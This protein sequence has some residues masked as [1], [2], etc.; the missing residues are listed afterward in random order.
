MIYQGSNLETVLKE[1]SEKEYTPV[2]ELTYVVLKNEENNVEIEVYTIVDVIEYAQNY[3]IDGIKALGFDSR[4]NP[5]LKDDIINL[6]IESDRNPI[7]IGKNGRSLQAL[8]E[9]V[10]LAVNHR[11]NRR[12]RILLNVSDY[13]EEKYSKISSFAKRIAHEVQKTKV[14]ATLDP[15]TADERR[16]VHNALAGMPHIR[17]ESSGFGKNRQINIIYVEDEKSEANN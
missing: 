16:T 17:T 2:E 7:I 14:N 5:T 3:I 15:M 8:N 4:V 9:L 13:K 11:F 12:Y 1:A 10:R 6:K